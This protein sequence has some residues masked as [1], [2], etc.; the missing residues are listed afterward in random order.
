MGMNQF[1]F[2]IND[3]PTLDIDQ[4]LYAMDQFYLPLSIRQTIERRILWGLLKAAEAEGF[5]A[6]EVYDGDELTKVTTKQEVME[7][8][9]NLDEV[10][11][12]F[13]N[14]ARRHVGHVYFI[15][16]NGNVGLDAITDWSWTETRDGEAFNKTIDAFSDKVQE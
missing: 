4:R 13:R 11:V 15:W 2:E 12:R 14:S 1:I 5:T 6:S 9:F 7:L 3:V 10:V 8:A 16:G